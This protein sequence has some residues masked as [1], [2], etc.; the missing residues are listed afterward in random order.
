[1]LKRRTALVT[2]LGLVAAAGV[3]MAIATIAARRAGRP[4]ACT[5]GSSEDKQWLAVAPGRVEAL[6]GQ[7]KIAA[8]YAG[9]VDKV[10]V[11][12]ND[13][14]FAGE[15]LIRLA[16]DELRARLAAAEAQVEVRKRAQDEKRATGK[17]DDPTQG[18]GCRGRCRAGG[19][20][21]A[22]RGRSRR[23]RSCGPKAGRTPR[24]IGARS[25]LARARDELT[26]REEELRKSRRTPFAHR[27]GGPAQCRPRRDAAARAALDKMTM[28]APID[29]TVLQVNVRAGE[30]AAPRLAS[31]AAA[32]GQCFGLARACGTGR[33]RSRF[34]QGW[35]SGIR[36]GIRVPRSRVRGKGLVDR[37]AR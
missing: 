31:A 23:E 6:S 25:E 32:A 19:I 20:R 15:P 35:A 36:A 21:G 8:P 9:L 14:V 33:T 11:K 1:M 24:L 37:A 2:V 16:D 27:R 22:N 26:R 12:A 3:V 7:I 4:R 10:L 17:A 29:G 13:K 30:L 34:N 5:P 18:Q 28:R